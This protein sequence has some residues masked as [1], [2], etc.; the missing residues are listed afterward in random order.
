[1]RLKNARIKYTWFEIVEFTFTVV[2]AVALFSLLAVAGAGC[3]HLIK[4]W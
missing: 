4:N 2:A 3:M 1:M